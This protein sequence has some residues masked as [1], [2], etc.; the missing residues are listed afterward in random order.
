MSQQSFKSTSHELCDLSVVQQSEMIR[1]REVSPVEVMS[2]VLQRIDTLNPQ[3][4]AFCTVDA[5]N[6]LKAARQAEQEVMRGQSLGPLHG[7]PA[8]IK[9]MIVTRGVRTTFG[10]RLY[11]DWIPDED[12][13][14]VA[15]LRQAGAIIVGKTNVP[16]FGYQAITD[17]KVW[18]L[19]RNPWDLSK[20]PGGSSG[21]TGAAVASGMVSLGIG[22]DGGGSIRLPAAFCG[23]YGF[24]PSFGRVPLYPGCR[25]PRYPGASSWESMECNGP[26][27]K[28][29]ADSALIMDVIAGPSPW[30]R[31]SL[32][33]EGLEYLAALADRDIRGLRIA[34]SMD[35]GFAVLDSEVRNVVQNAIT[36]FEHLGAHV[37]R[38]D[39]DIGD[40]SDVFQ[41]LVARDSDLK[42]LRQLAQQHRDEMGAQIL[43]V[44]DRDW[45]AEQLTDAHFQRQAT[46]MTMHCLMDEYDLF[47][48]PTLAVTPFDVGVAGPETIDG[49]TVSA[50]AW[51]PFTCLA[52]LTGQPAASVPAGWTD[53]GLPVGLQIIGRRLE[54]L[55][56]LR[57][58]AVFE[59]AR[60]WA[61][62]RP[63]LVQSIINHQV[64]R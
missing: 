9:D 53:N 37:E 56:V 1:K 4:N 45:S 50:A 21:G 52:N 36:V 6:A 33:N 64:S 13:V 17:N 40:L 11:A 20:T 61:H 15:R 59:D 8:G 12:D 62:R 42:G 32:P 51:K 46:C 35:F 49:E 25:D 58:S 10:S 2:S 28:T 24:K 18:G 47:L 23:I 31:H 27:T 14:C 44:V 39:P 41:G 7:V 30:D 63:A 57:A 43:S 60:P 22:N 19:T 34:F 3:V 29:V 5:E 55:T 48:T 16:E 54:D 38:V 26:M